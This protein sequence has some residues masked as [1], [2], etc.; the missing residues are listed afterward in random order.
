MLLATALVVLI[1]LAP[2]RSL[3]FEGDDYEWLQAARAADRAPGFELPADVNGHFRPAAEALWLAGWTTF[4]LD[5]GPYHRGTLA[6]HT[7][8]AALVGLV[9]LLLVGRLSAG[10]A[11]VMVFGLNVSHRTVPTWTSAAP[12]LILGF[13]AALAIAGLLGRRTRW[14]GVIGFAVALAAKESALALVVCL[15]LVAPAARRGWQRLALVSLTVAAAIPHLVA[16]SLSPYVQQRFGFG[17]H[18]PRM[19]LEAASSLMVPAAAAG[20]SL[21]PE[22]IY[23]HDS[24]LRVALGSA[25]LVVAVALASRVIGRMRALGW[26][27]AVVVTLLLPSLSM[28]RIEAR[29][30]YLPWVLLAPLV[31]AAI[32]AIGDAAGHALGR[33]ATIWVVSTVIVG[34]ALAHGTALRSVI[35]G[36]AERQRLGRAI[37][38]G[39]SERPP[40][41][42]DDDVVEV[43]V[44]F[45]AELRGWP[46]GVQLAIDHDV[47]VVPVDDRSGPS[48]TTPVLDATVDPAVWR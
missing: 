40:L 1:G 31:S 15:P 44:P 25:A 27:A 13:G 11:A 42:T 7:L 41:L 6:V 14:L 16:W 29:W 4:G 36:A 10:V 38:S 48:G 28:D 43:L 47:R 12:D 21:I 19:F 46:V 3:F 35:A 2:A 26:A 33:R 24:P 22:W 5:A 39:A 32:V 17:R 9:A 45:G 8:T 30:L 20:H 23:R 34:H 18:V 37:V